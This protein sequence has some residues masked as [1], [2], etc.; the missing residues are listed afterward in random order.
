MINPLKRNRPVCPGCKRPALIRLGRCCLCDAEVHFPAAYF[1]WLWFL[2][3]LSLA[4][5]GSFVLD[6]QHIGTWLLLLIIL[7][8]PVRIGW[9][10][11]I[12]PWLERGQYK[13][14]WPFGFLYLAAFV[15]LFLEWTA[16]GWLHVGL[17]ATRAELSENWFFFSI[18]LCWVSSKFLI[19]SD[20][21]LSD[22]IGTILGNAFFYAVGAF[23]L[24]RTVSS[25]LNRNRAIRLKITDSDPEGEN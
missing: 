15:T 2:T 23:A 1:R 8:L 17:G 18:P 11:V 6:S 4:G 25:R 10:F 21:W 22:A 14:G 3:F 9:G 16:W 7:S 24:Y 19:R 20:R 5:I 13:N 12:P